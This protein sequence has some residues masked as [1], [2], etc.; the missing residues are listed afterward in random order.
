MAQEIASVFKYI[1]QGVYVISV[2]DGE[3]V[4]AFTAAWVMQVSFDPPLI[5]FSINPK[6]YSYE[7]LKKGE[8]CC[9][10]VLG[11]EQFVEANHFGRSVSKDKMSDFLWLKTETGAPALAESLAYFDCRVEHFSGAGDH[12]LVVCRVVDAAFI[13]EGSPMLYVDTLDMDKSGELYKK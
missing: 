10:S 4:N 5:C 13:Q 3:R 8:V 1:S 9:V 6:H 11:D 2:S 12:E 7:I